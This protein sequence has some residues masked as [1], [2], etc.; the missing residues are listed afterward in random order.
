M[1]WSDLRYA[2]RAVIKNPRFSLVAVAALALGIGANAAIFSVVNTVLLQ[3]LPYP[4]PAGW[5][6]CA[7]SSRAA[8]QMREVDSEVHGVVAR[9]VDGRDR[10]LRLRR[11]RAQPERRRPAASR[12]R[13]STCR[14][15]FPRLRRAARDRAAP[16]PRTRTPGGPRVAVHHRT[17]LWATH[18]G[19]RSAIVGRTIPERRSLHGRRRP[20]GSDSAPSRRPTSSFRC[21]PIRTAPTRGT[22]SRSRAI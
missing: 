5:C 14:R 20:A 17:A 2:C 4:E 7:A 6:A 16:S 12:S 19:E 10:R 11:P 1:L 3:P 18:F 9:A 8:P 15:V 21:R 13:A 22:T